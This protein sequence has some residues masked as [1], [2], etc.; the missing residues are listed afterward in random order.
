MYDLSGKVAL[1]T[2]AGGELG[3]GRAIATRL[4]REGADVIVNDIT[5][6]PYADRDTPW[7]GI[8]SVVQEIEALGTQAIPLVADVSNAG[9]VQDMV[10]QGVER[11]GHIDILVNNAGSRPGKDRVLV[12]DLE[13]EAWDTVQRVNA[14][15]TFLCSQVVARQMIAQGTGGK[16]INISSGAGKRGR[17]RFAAYCASKF[18]VLGF[19]EALSLEL[20]QYS[21]NVNAICP[22]L[23][24]TE[25]AAYIARALAPEGESAIEYHAQMIRE[26]ADNIPLGRVADGPDIANTAAFLASAEADYLTGLS[27]PVAGGFLY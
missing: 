6:N 22:G 27:I 4:A 23:V 14:K 18:A 10:R 17:A 7:R 16:I 5:D 11:F 3:I 1:I 9:Q 13:E 24:D 19:T 26:R 15:G 8:S 20:A 12:V 25:R 2:G 21:I